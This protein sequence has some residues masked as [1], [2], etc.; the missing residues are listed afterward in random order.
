MSAIGGAYS[1][2]SGRPQSPGLVDVRAVAAAAVAAAAAVPEVGGG[3]A[4]QAAARVEVAVLAGVQGAPVGGQ[5]GLVVGARRV[6]AG[7]VGPG[8]R[9]RQAVVA[10]AHRSSVTGPWA[11]V[12]S[13]PIPPPWLRSA[14]PSLAV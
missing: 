12:G 4:P 13:C 10:G 11:G 8:Q 3:E 1:S 2:R 6:E 7:R 5:D 14:E 9:G